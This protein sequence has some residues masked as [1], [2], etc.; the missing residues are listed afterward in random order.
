MSTGASLGPRSA[1][2]GRERERNREAD[3]SDRDGQACAFC[4]APQAVLP[5]RGVVVATIGFSA[6]ALY[7]A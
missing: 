4:K 3:Q 2:G 5:W 1:M 6:A 7:A